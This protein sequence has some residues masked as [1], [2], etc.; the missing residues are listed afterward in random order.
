MSPTRLPVPW[1]AGLV[2]G[3]ALLMAAGL[4]GCGGSKPAASTPS[5]PPIASGAAGGRGAGGPA[6]AAFGVA[7][8]ISGSSIEVQD[9]NTGQ[10]TVNFTSKTA[11]SQTRTVSATALAVGECVTAISARTTGSSASPAPSSGPLTSFSAATVTIAPA[12]NGSCAAGF[13]GR[14][15][16]GRPAGSGFPTGARPSGSG[17]SGTGGAGTG[18]GFGGGAGFGGVASGKLSQLSGSTMQVLVAARGSRPSSTDTITL[19]ASTS[20]TETVQVNSTALKVGQCV[21]ATG[22]A[23]S[24]GAVAATRIALSTA[25][26]NGC[27]TGFGRRPRPSGSATGA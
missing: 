27:S 26:P 20:Y 5:I 10:V 9:P 15:G 14:G 2:A 6:P 23:N 16:T 22:S 18:G 11:F 12:V 17:G 1:R 8:A 21:S 7:A 4:A 19:T 13:G 25:G 3:S 24:T